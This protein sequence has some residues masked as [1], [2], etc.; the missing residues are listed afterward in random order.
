MRVKLSLLGNNVNGLRNKLDTLYN[1]IKYFRPSIITLQETKFKSKGMV[2]LNGYEI[3]EFIRSDGSGGGLLTAVD[4]NLDPAEVECADS[5]DTE[6]LIVQCRVGNFNLRIVNAYAPQED[7]TS[8]ETVDFWTKIEE[9][10]VAAKDNDC[11]IIVQL[12][13]NAKVGKNVIK[14][15]LFFCQW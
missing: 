3:F 14:T 4:E 9:E 11:L 8:G 13:G 12:D 7:E 10:I 6:I 15:I 5:G 2:K 1:N